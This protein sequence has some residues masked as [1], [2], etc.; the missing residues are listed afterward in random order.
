MARV[1]REGAGS[2]IEVGREGSVCVGPV[3]GAEPQPLAACS[4][5][6]PG[7]WAGSRPQAQAAPANPYPIPSPGWT[8]VGNPAGEA[9]ALSVSRS[10]SG[11]R[12]LP[13]DPR[14]DWTWQ[15]QDNFSATI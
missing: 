2:G 14:G 12:R 15:E 5:P 11:A 4:A 13:R 10:A 9:L 6:R 3:S 1:S 8:I 7:T